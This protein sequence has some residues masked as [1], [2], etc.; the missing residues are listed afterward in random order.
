MNGQF[1]GPTIYARKG[2]TIT[3]SVYNQGNKNITLHWHGVDQPRNP[4]FDGPEF[5]TQCPIKPGANFTYKII[6]SEEEG[7]LW[8]HA[9]SDFDRA[10]VH[11][12]IVIYPK[13]GS[14]EPYGKT[15]IET[16]II[17]GEWWNED[18]EKLLE[19]NLRTGGEIP[20]SEA[21]TINGQPGDLINPACS[22]NGTFRVRVGRGKRHLLRVINAGLSNEMFFAVAGHSLTV[23][24]TDGHYLKPFTTDYIMISPGQTMNMLLSPKRGLRIKRRY[25]MA[26]RTF[27]TNT[28]EGG[29]AVDNTTATA[30]LEYVDVPPSPGP[31]DFPAQ[32]PNLTDVPAAT[33]YTAR[34][35]SLATRDHP[36]D[37][38]T[39]VDE[40]LF[41]TVSLNTLPCGAN[42]NCT[43]PGENNTNSRLSASLNNVSF[44]N[45]TVDIL[46]AYYY[47][48]SG[49]Y[50]SDFPNRPPSFFNFTDDPPLNQTFTE[51][52]TKVKVVEYGTVVEVVFQGTGILGAEGHPMHLHGYAFYV[53]GQGFGIFDKTKDP[54][55]Y[56]LVDP[57]HQNTVSVPK[58]GWAAIRFRATNPGVWYMHCHFDRHTVWGMNTVFIVKNGKT[59]R[60]RML[61][62]P[63]SMPKC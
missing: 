26:A 10:T 13:R 20:V 48:M 19:D 2:D 22:R 3:V 40:H 58:A 63:R 56:N 28:A 52:G 12:A 27:V 50:E 18:V 60:T 44:V 8:W 47:S 54:K 53:V 42:E 45:P 9:H 37:V 5:I 51:K 35:R 55:S 4:W 61:P 15:D 57:P 46:D 11:G 6:L 33:A 21:N 17:I 25:Y 31:P 16:P 36:V 39:R 24:G 43:G 30:I 1:P 7:T 23:V 32:L 62:R 34:L 49:V 41:V 14:V 38:P 29:I 59:P